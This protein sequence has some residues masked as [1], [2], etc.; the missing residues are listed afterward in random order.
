MPASLVRSQL[1]ILELPDGQERAIVIETNGLGID[2][3]LM[4]IIDK[5]KHM[6]IE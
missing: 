1:D 2:D 6:D 3:I 5:L 4:R